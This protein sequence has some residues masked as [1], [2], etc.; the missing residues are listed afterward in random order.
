MVVIYVLY[1]CV[2]VFDI[3]FIVVPFITTNNI[4]DVRYDDVLDCFTIDIKKC[5]V[6]EAFC[7]DLVVGVFQLL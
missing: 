5:P 7:V 2:V 4:L 6:F 3:F 1:V